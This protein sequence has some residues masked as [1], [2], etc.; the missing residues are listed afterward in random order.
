MTI[1]SNTM[2]FTYCGQYSISEH[3]VHSMDVGFTGE[4]DTCSDMSFG[5]SHAKE[6]PTGR[7]VNSTSNI[8]EILLLVELV[9]NISAGVRNCIA[10]VKLNFL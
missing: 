9:H 7:I 4:V 5:M 6:V 1:H 8:L 2:A 10:N 3:I